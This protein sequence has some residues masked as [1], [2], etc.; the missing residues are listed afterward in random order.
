MNTDMTRIAGMTVEVGWIFY[1]QRCRWCRLGRQWTGRLFESR[2]FRWVP[3]QTPGA[4]ARLGVPESDFDRRLHVLLPGGR[5]CDNADAL[6]WLCR[7]VGWLWPVGALL[8]VPGF[9]DLG[10]MAYDFIARHRYCGAGGCWREA[11]V[12]GRGGAR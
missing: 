7:S 8:T 4:A 10:R 6:G 1:D 11:A 9:R 2:G 12:E 5:V 3:L